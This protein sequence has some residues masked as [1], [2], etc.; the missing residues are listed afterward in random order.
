MEGTL[1]SSKAA[2]RTAALE[3]LEYLNQQ[4][5]RHYK[6][7]KSHTTM[8]EARLKDH[9][10]Q[11]LR[12]VIDSKVE[13][14]GKN[15]KMEPYLRPQTLFNAKNCDGYVGVFKPIVGGKK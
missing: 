4:A 10:L 3:V 7:T 1:M 5:G 13:E 6:P 2:R 15:E 14:W 8:I 9:S 12:D 11:D